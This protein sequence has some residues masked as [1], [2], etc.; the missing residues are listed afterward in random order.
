MHAMSIASREAC[1]EKDFHLSHEIDLYMPFTLDRN[2]LKF[3]GN[4]V[5]NRFL[6]GRFGD[7][8][9]EE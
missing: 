5:V 4:F 3:V 1:F 9:V 8:G 6:K 2:S 7:T